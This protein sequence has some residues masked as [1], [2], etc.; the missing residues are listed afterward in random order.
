MIVLLCKKKPRYR[1]APRHQHVVALIDNVLSPGQEVQIASTALQAAEGVFSIDETLA[2]M[3]V[4]IN[5]TVVAA[6]SIS[7]TEST[8]S[9]IATTHLVIGLQPQREFSIK[10]EDSTSLQVP[11]PWI[12]SL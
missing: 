7:V 8:L 10:I 2:T 6:T 1:T 5:T 3:L 4:D 9:C 12:K 11:F